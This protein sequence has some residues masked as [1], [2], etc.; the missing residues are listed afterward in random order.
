MPLHTGGKINWKDSNVKDS[1]NAK[2]L[3]IDFSIDFIEKSI[4]EIRHVTF[5]M[6]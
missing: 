5:I 6:Y 1:V 3:V 2:Q 4:T